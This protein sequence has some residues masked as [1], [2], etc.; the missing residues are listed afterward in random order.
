MSIST[1]NNNGI[2]FKHIIYYI[3]SIIKLI[4]YVL[5]TIA[6]IV[7]FV[8]IS[9]QFSLEDGIFSVLP[10]TIYITALSYISYVVVCCVIYLAFWF[11]NLNPLDRIY[12]RR[13]SILSILTIAFSNKWK[14]TVYI[15]DAPNIKF[16]I[17]SA[18]SIYV[19]LRIIK[20]VFIRSIIYACIISYIAYIVHNLSKIDNEKGEFFYILKILIGIN[21]ANSTLSL[22]SAVVMFCMVAAV[23][24]VVGDLFRLVSSFITHIIYDNQHTADV[25]SKHIG[26]VKESAKSVPIKGVVQ[27]MIISR[28]YH[29]LGLTGLRKDIREL[30]N[31]TL[32]LDGSSKV[33]IDYNVE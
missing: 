8:L 18:D 6:G 30:L 24:S 20:K 14:K 19:I 33:I 15:E 29:S 16:L 9:K 13:F 1:T 31:I 10:N 26:E 4:S 23:I 32:H 21:M 5:C 25:L 2:G 7:Y 28:I 11:T 3:M 22:F 27:Q 17:Y 12:R